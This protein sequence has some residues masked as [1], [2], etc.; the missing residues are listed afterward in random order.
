METDKKKCQGC[1]KSLEL[2]L[3]EDEK[4][5]EKIYSKCK[6]CRY[7]INNKNKKNICEICGIRARYNF[8]NQKNGI[9][10]KE[11]K[12][13]NMIDI[14]STLCI[15]CNSKRPS[16]NFESGS[17]AAYCKN[18]SEIGMINIKHKKCIS[19]KNKV[20][21][22]IKKGEKIPSYCKE[23]SKDIPVSVNKKL[24]VKCN[25]TRPT[26]NKKDEKIPLYCK[27]CRED[28]MVDVIS[29]K[30]VV[31]KI[32]Q[33]CFSFITDPKATHCKKCSLEGMIDVKNKKCIICQEKQPHFG[34][35]NKA[36]HCKNCSTSE[37]ICVRG[38]KCVVCNKIRPNFNYIGEN[39]ATHCKNCSL[40]GMVDVK[41]KKCILCKKKYATFGFSEDNKA[42]HCK[43][44]SLPDMIDVFHKK[45]I[46]EECKINPTFGYCGQ[47][48]IYCLKHRDQHPDKNLLFAKP[49]RT[50]IGNDEEDCKDI[51][52]FGITEP[53]HCFD[54]SL[55]N[56]INL[57]GLNCKGCNRKEL[58][59][60]QG[61]CVYF[62]APNEIY[63]KQKLEKK[64]ENL[65]LNYLDH[66]YKN[67]NIITIK[68]DLIINSKCNLYRPDRI[69]DFGTHYVIIE[70][71]EF[72][73][74]S[75]SQYCEL[76][77]MHEVQ[78]AAGIN[79]IFIRFNPDNFRVKGVVQK[80]NSK[81][82]LKILVKWIEK[83]AEIKPKNDLE[84]VK[85]KYLFY[86]EFDET[87]LNFKI[88]DD[89]EL[90]KE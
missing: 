29:D 56:E 42:T 59:N 24:C 33:P 23:C 53:L 86:D 15:K 77:R 11:H 25:K 69:Y 32:T 72:Q 12:E 40:E 41:N 36:T 26:Y 71:D 54:H 21:S 90:S 67:E 61:Y 9:R 31:C 20:A 60:N 89:L 88:I 16:F 8:T 52:T 13:L 38:K 34:L 70:I 28:D 85:V 57:I 6:E 50:C 81:E 1:K 64:K 73:H 39:K 5:S 79:C 62:C 63:Q 84:P 76:R 48:P 30:C 55:P 47:A 37:M 45:C 75:Y 44:C 78:N 80:I 46:I 65:V 22:F 27:K 51:A 66:N 10:C 43:D 19:C 74:S 17:N 82:R 18:C 49:K 68:D 3:F 14:M 7:K 35:E 87:D 2:Y 58:L 4:K 83:C